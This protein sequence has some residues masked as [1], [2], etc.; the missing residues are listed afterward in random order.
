MTFIP[1]KSFRVAF[2]TTTSEIRNPDGTVVFR[3]DSVEVPQRWSQ[4]ASDV[5]AQKYFRKAGVPQYD[6][7]GNPEMSE[8]GEPLTGPERDARQVFNRLAG[9]W[10]DWGKRF[11]YFDTDDEN[12]A[13]LGEMARLLADYYRHRGWDENGMPAP[14]GG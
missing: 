11:G 5:I 3:L 8:S 6:E 13:A 2:T 1:G 14:S 10:T 7:D 12:R 4:V 9:C